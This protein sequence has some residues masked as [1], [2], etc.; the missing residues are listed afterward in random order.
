MHTTWT[1]E[2]VK[3]ELTE[4]FRQAQGQAVFSPSKG[5]VFLAFGSDNT[6]QWD[7]VA[8]SYYALGKDRDSRARETR[9]MLLTWCRLASQSHKDYDASLRAVCSQLKWSRSTF[10]R[11]VEQ[12][13]QQMSDMLEFATMNMRSLHRKLSA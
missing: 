2:R 7:L 8:A 10:H 3:A 13:A 4:A 9:L 12:A 1:P 6:A 5:E 11:R